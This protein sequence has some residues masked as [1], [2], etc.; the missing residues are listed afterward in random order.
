MQRIGMIV[1][2]T[3]AALRGR[4]PA[5]GSRV[6]SAGHVLVQGVSGHRAIAPGVVRVCRGGV[7]ERVRY[8]GR[9]ETQVWVP[10]GLASVWD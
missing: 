9:P 2:A 4:A 1:A 7:A 6:L 5:A 8:V 10:A 3:R